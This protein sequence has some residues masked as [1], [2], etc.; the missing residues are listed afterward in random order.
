MGNP[1]FDRPLPGLS[2]RRG[3][4]TVTPLIRGNLSLSRRD[5]RIV[6]GSVVLSNAAW[7]I[8]CYG[9]IEAVRR[10]WGKV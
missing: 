6:F 10:L 3:P 4:G 8:V 5:R 9:G 2:P 1:G 7:A